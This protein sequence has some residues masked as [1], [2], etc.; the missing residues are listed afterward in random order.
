MKSESNEDKKIAI[1]AHKAKSVLKKKELL[2]R[3]HVH[4]KPSPNMLTTALPEFSPTTKLSMTT[5]LNTKLRQIKPSL[6]D[7]EQCQ[8]IDAGC[9]GE[10]VEELGG[11]STR[12]P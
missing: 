7:N 12:L 2:T 1:A 10:E 6:M 3:Q 11:T 4:F 5:D 9:T 8:G